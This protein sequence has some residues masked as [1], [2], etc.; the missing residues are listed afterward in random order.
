MTQ[1]DS[2]TT[3]ACDLSAI[4]AE[5]RA[6]HIALART[7]LF[8]DGNAEP[9]DDG[10]RVALSPDRLREVMEFVENERRCCSHLGFSIELAAR[11]GPLTLAITGPGARLELEAS[12]A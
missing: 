11:G 7:L 1:I 4:P 5:Q 9:V 3:V 8:A 6:A 2:A 10:Y 12:T